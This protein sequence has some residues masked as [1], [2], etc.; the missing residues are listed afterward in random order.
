MHN[1]QLYTNREHFL[2]ARYLNLGNIFSLQYNASHL[3]PLNDQQIVSEASL[4]LIKCI[5]DFEEASVIQQF[6]RRSPR[7]AMH[8]LPGR[9]KFYLTVMLVRKWK[10]TLDRFLFVRIT[11]LSLTTTIIPHA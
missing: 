4:C 6:V 1:Q 9:L 3:F 8:F 2:T 5:R 7:S 10:N 11:K